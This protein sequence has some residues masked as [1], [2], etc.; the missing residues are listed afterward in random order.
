MPVEVRIVSAVVLLCSI[1]WWARCTFR[2]EIDVRGAGMA[3]LFGFV[4]GIGLLAH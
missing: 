3:C 4:S 2:D 1:A